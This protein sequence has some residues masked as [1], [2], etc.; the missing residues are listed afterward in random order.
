MLL[1]PHRPCLSARSPGLSPP[2]PTKLPLFAPSPSPKGKVKKLSQHSAAPGSVQEGPTAAT[3]APPKP[4]PRWVVGDGLGSVPPVQLCGSESFPCS[5]S[6]WLSL[7]LWSRARAPWCNQLAVQGSSWQ[8]RCG[9][10]LPPLPGCRLAPQDYP[11]RGTGSWR[12]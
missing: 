2:A 11:Q 5:R 3:K 4:L 8:K 9:A 7:L 10:R 6:R 12:Q 1:S